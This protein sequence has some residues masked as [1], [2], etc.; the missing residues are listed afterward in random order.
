MVSLLLK[1]P[2]FTLKKTATGRKLVFLVVKKG[3]WAKACNVELEIA[4]NGL[5][6]LLKFIL[7]SFFASNPFSFF[8]SL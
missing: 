5:K 6:I 4:S 7:I 8:V 1:K 3:F 2:F